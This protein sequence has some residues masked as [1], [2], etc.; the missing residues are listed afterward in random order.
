VSV[1]ALDCHD[2]GPI[3]LDDDISEWQ[4]PAALVH[5]WTH[6]RLLMLQSSGT[7]GATVRGSSMATARL[8]AGSWRSCSSSCDKIGPARRTTFAS[9]FF[10]FG[11]NEL[12]ERSHAT[13]HHPS[14]GRQESKRNLA[15]VSPVSGAAL[16]THHTHGTGDAQRHNLHFAGSGPSRAPAKGTGEQKLWPG[17]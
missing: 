15:N 7:P 11:V 8:P 5:L 6:L 13:I 3:L 1:R 12:Y 2:A 16:N 10:C 14:K 9:S 4:P 17:M